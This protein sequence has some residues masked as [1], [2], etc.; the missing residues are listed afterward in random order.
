M[1][2]LWDAGHSHIELHVKLDKSIFKLELKSNERI[3]D[4]ACC[5]TRSTVE[6]LQTATSVSVFS[7]G[8]DE[9]CR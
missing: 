3:Y 7:T 6:L 2:Q 8:V 5:S 4:S 9:G 1:S